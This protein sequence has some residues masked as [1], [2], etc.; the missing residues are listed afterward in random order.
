MFSSHWSQLCTALL[1]STLLFSLSTATPLHHLKREDTCAYDY[2]IVGGGTAGLTLA[3][4]LTADGTHSVI[5]LEAGDKPT[6]VQPYQVPG[7]DQQVTGSPIDWNFGTVP[8]SG[9]NDRQLTYSQGK[10]LGGSSAINGLAYT[11]A[12]ASIYD[13]WA[14]LG[15]DG[16]TWNEVLPYFIKVPYFL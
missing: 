9:L 1:S 14:S 2:I 5:V 16:W 6:I 4:R 12:S 13:K 3:N 8:Q 10:C 11:R 7:A 15:N